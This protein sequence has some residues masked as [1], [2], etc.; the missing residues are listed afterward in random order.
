LVL[1]QVLY[2]LSGLT[3]TDENFIIKSGAQ[4]A[5]AAHGVALVAP[6][7]SPR[8]SRLNPSLVAFNF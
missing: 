8:T 3:C 6:D 2:W 5:A 1:A 7:T 4:R